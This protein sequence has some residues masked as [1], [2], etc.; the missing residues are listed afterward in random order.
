MKKDY[1]I[2][3]LNSI[4]L[5]LTPIVG[6]VGTVLL[7]WH[8]MVSWPT[9]ILAFVM[10]S[11][12]GFGITLGYHRLFSHRSFKAHPVVRFVLAVLTA[13]A[14]QGS[15]LEWST[16]HRDHHRYTD[17][18]K[19]PYS[20]RKGF[21]YAHFGWLLVL[22]PAKRDFSNVAD[23]AA[24]PVLRF[25]HKYFIPLAIATGF[26]LPMAIGALWGNAWAGLLVAGFL[27]LTINHHSTFAINSICHMFGKRTYSDDQSACDNWVTAILTNGEGYH[28][29]HHQFPIDYRNAV[30]FYQYDP[31]K[32][33][34]YAL[35]KVGLASDLKRV[36]DTKI[37]QYRLRFQEKQ[38]ELQAQ[39]NP[40][41]FITHLREM[42]QPVHQRMQSLL[43]KIDELEKSYKQLKKAKM[44]YLS[45]KMEEYRHLV[46]EHRKKIRVAKQELKH[47][48]AIWSRLIHDKTLKAAVAV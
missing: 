40:N 22:D 29:F 36:S 44:D 26:L 12:S 32:W 5:T 46:K 20:I 17:T 9:W 38:I 10:F 41:A 28:N 1:K 3:W 2:N 14:F 11:I 16:D 21:W 15:V 42:V 47:S 48:L 43:V 8:G 18:D 23:L 25:Q 31:T 24:D 6:I 19:D 39:K 34:I 33:I 45:G 35:S 37:L 30:R 27:R 13:G 4:F 7:I